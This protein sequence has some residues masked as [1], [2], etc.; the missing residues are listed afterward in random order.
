[1]RW[2]AGGHNPHLIEGKREARRVRDREVAEM[3]RVER[4]PD[5]TDAAWRRHSF[6]AG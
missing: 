6:N 5:E 4:A 3:E 1:M 2:D